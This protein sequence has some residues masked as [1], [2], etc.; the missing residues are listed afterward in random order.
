MS[1]ADSRDDG[2][3]IGTKRFWEMQGNIGLAATMRSTAHWY[4]VSAL[5]LGTYGR[6]TNQERS[7]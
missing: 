3:E 4:L 1:A 7:R 5:D 2:D 6:A